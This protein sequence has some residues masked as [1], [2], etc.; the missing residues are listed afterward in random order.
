M[1]KKFNILYVY[2]ERIPIAIRKLVINELK[3]YNFNIKSMTYKTS[4]D[5]Q[6][7]LFAWSDSVFFGPGRYINPEAISKMKKKI[8]FSYG[9]LDMISLM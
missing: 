3:N 9:A 2:E 1:K 4:I 6:K 5:S 7:K 8:F